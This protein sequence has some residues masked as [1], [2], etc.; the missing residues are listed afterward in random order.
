MKFGY[1]IVIFILIFIMSI[2]FFSGDIT[3]TLFSSAAE[4]TTMSE[5]TLPT[6]TIDV[7]GNEIN[8]LHGYSANL[9]AMIIR[10]SITPL[11]DDRTFTL[12]IHNTESD[13]KKL[14]Y[15][16]LNEDGQE[17]E[18]DSLTV[19]DV[20][21]GPKKVPITL[22]ETLKSGKEYVAKFTLIT[23][24][25]KRIYY[26]T[27]L[28]LYSDGLLEDKLRFADYFHDTLLYGEE[29]DKDQLKKYLE[30]AKNY[31][32]S[33]F[34]HVTIN[35]SFDM[36]SWGELKPTVVWEQVPTVTEFY[37][38]IASIRRQFVVSLETGTGLEYFTVKED[39][40]FQYTPSKTYLYNYDRKMEAQFDVA[41]TSLVKNEFKLGITS[42]TDAQAIASDSGK[43]MA[44]VYG[45][46]LIVYDV[47]NNRL[48]KAF[49]FKDG[50]RDYER[51]YFDN[52]D[53][54]ILKVHDDGNVDFIVYGYM[55]RGEYEGRV[56][57]VLYR[58]VMDDVRIEEQL[59]VPINTSYWLLL[60]DM[61]DFMFLS[62]FDVFYFSLYDSVYSYSLVTRE[63]KCLAEDVPD[64]NM[65]FVENELYL[66]WQSESDL[67]NS[68]ELQVFDL[69][70]DKITKITAPK[71][72]TVRLLG[73]INDNFIYGYQKL[74]DK[75]INLD[76]TVDLPSYKL[77]ISDGHCN[78]LKEYTYSDVWIEGV[79]PGDGILIIN[80][81]KKK[82]GVENSYYAVDYDSIVNLPTIVEHSVG[83]SRRVTDRILTEYY[84]TVP[85]GVDITEIP[86]QY[87]AV[88][89]VIDFDTTTRVSEPED[90]PWLYYAYSFSEIAY[91]SLDP[92]RAIA[93]ADENVGTVIN[94]DGRL[95]W[96]RGIKSVRSE[97]SGIETFK[98]GNGLD[99]RQAAMKMILRYKNISTDPAEY[100]HDKESMYSWL[101][102]NMKSSVINLTGVTLDEMLYYVYKG[103][104]VIAMKPDGNAVVVTAYDSSSITVYEP[105]RAGTYKYTLK[106]A[107][108]IF[109][110]AGNV[111]ISYI[112]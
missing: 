83:L 14:K 7:G 56:G 66:V 73:K 34:A 19:L 17:L 107:F 13:V 75:Y 50:S 78:V 24:N 8:L 9:D 69:K 80:R 28:K 36:V 29:S 76:G 79:E 72:E 1:K 15:E 44:F 46:E 2:V 58:F 62:E 104:P 40:R 112:D 6:V 63:V 92:A 48:F 84:V 45:C 96:E 53:I 87:N 101:S 22:R 90:K 23:N 81:V 20:I 103:R 49:S 85:S 38:N 10:E 68:T 55:N 21:D 60:A 91:A 39:F 11:T 95:I 67:L 77:C 108:E 94:K 18:S 25:S 109:N 52:H 3:E 41:N 86:V 61:T 97:I 98:A 12:L 100:N 93:V 37:N 42:D 65:V 70:E 32:N 33:S 27:R 16:I 102:R 106:E 110:R 43:Y 5:A 74:S 35:S 82:L 26:Y 71:G 4:T 30:P 47:D 99:S 54:K 59:Y 105:A 64:G 88:P 57:L 51:D 111:F 31:D 89:T